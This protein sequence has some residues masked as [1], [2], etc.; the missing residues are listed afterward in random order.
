MVKLEVTWMD[1]LRWVLMFLCGVF[2][3]IVSSSPMVWIFAGWGSFWRTLLFGLVGFLVSFIIINKI[4]DST[5]FY[6]E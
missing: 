5:K 1:R 3:W 6:P 4:D 2:C